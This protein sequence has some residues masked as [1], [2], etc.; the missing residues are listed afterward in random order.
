MISVRPS[1][2]EAASKLLIRACAVILHARRICLIRR[3]RPGGNQYSLPGGIVR[4]DET[5]PAALARELK[6]ELDLDVD[7]LPQQ[8][9]LHW[10]QDQ[11]TTRP[12]RPELF[13]RLHLVHLLRLTHYLRPTLTTVEQHAEEHSQVVW[14]GLAQAARLHLYP[15]VADVFTALVDHHIAPV[16]VLLP[17]M[18]DQ[19][20]IWR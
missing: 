13:R 10:V 9:E 6:E 19:T 20:Y 3:I 4:Q 16:P 8:P 5:V 14:V 12:G 11:L 15:A 18:T 7:A 17:P 1:S 2:G